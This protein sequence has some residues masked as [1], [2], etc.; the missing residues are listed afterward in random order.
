MFGS[1]LCKI[2]WGKHYMAF[3]KVV[4][5]SEIYNFPIHHFVHFYST[6]WSYACSNRVSGKRFQR[7]TS[8]CARRDVARAPR[9]SASPEAAPS[10]G[11][12]PP[13]RGSTHAELLR[14]PHCPRRAPWRVHAGLSPF[15]CPT[16]YESCPPRFSPVPPCSKSQTLR[17]FNPGSPFPPRAVEG[18]VGVNL[19]PKGVTNT[20]VLF[21]S[22]GAR[23]QRAP[24]ED[25]TFFHY[26]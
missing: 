13:P 7:P 1:R 10:L 21:S 20:T 23:N 5:G 15:S 3:V 18:T 22:E 9:R 2:R 17:L 11:R 16:P 8:Y 24:S 4:E 6:F 14:N 19:V 26:C 25:D 12:G